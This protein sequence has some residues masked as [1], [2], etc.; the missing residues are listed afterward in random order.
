MGDLTLFESLTGGAFDCLRRQHRGEFD[1]I[2][3]SKSNAPGF[4]RGGRGMGSFG[5]DWYIKAAL[6]STALK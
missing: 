4:A 1:Q 6:S 2:F 3:S 5:I